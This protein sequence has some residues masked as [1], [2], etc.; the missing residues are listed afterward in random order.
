M[1][2]TPGQVL[3]KYVDGNGETGYHFWCPGCKI[4]H[5]CKTGPNGWQF[6][7]DVVK[8][9]FKPSLLVTG[10]DIRCHSFIEDGC[11]RFLNDCTHELAGQTVPL[12]PDP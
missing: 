10:G 12:E 9:T 6:N 3:R 2:D 7:G 8:P 5:G 4:Y 11:M 1:T